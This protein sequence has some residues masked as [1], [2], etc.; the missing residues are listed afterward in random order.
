[1]FVSMEGMLWT[2][3]PARV[4][5]ADRLAPGPAEDA[6]ER[7]MHAFD[8]RST[9]AVIGAGGLRSA[10]SARRHSIAPPALADA[11][12][13]DLFQVIAARQGADVVRVDARR[14]SPLTSMP[15]NCPT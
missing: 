8:V 15:S 1:M 11:A 9:P 2:I 4:R 10:R 7:E 14:A 13:D 12:V 3:A 5:R 6:G